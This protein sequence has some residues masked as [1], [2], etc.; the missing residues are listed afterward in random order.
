MWVKV[1]K[2]IHEEKALIVCSLP[3]GSSS[4]Q[5]DILKATSKLSEKGL[6]LSFATRR[7]TKAK[8]GELGSSDLLPFRQKK[9]FEV[10]ILEVISSKEALY[11]LYGSQDCDLRDECAWEGQI[12]ELLERI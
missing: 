11:A 2:A 6:D 9:L 5:I 10:T 7:K 4:I 8:L 1:V 3:I 12:Y